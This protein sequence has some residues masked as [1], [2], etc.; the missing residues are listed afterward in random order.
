M[1]AFGQYPTRLVLFELRQAN[2]AF[3]RGIRVALG[4][5]SEDRERLE[6]AR[7]QAARRNGGVLVNVENELPSTSVTAAV[8]GTKVAGTE[9]QPAGVEVEDEGE[10]DDEEQDDDGAE[11]DSAA[12]GV[13]V[14]VIRGNIRGTAA[15][16][17]CVT[18]ATTH[19]F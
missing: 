3:E 6:H 17:I 2:G 14:I 9:E 16:S 15:E 11:H 19:G 4:G 7:I 12:N 18:A 5:E 8:A 1:L 13:A 10:Y